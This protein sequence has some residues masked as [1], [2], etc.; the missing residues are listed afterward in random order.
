M[1]H[2]FARREHTVLNEKGE[3]RTYGGKAKKDVEMWGGDIL[4]E[5]DRAR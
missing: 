5:K 3:W 1:V 2:A 4:M